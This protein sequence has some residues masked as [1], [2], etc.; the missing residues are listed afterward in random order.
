MLPF[1]KRVVEHFLPSIEVTIPSVEDV[2]SLS[3]HLKALEE[4]R[5]HGEGVKELPR[6]PNENSIGF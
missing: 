6:F 5:L 2:I 1:L 4:I 3:D